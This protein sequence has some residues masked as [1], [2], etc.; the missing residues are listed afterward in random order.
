MVTSR[1]YT[2]GF[3]LVDMV[4]GQGIAY[5]ADRSIYMASAIK[6]PYVVSVM[7]MHPSAA[8]T[9]YS[10]IQSITRVSS[11]EAY[12]ALRNHF[13]NACMVEWCRKAGIDPN[14]GYRRWTDMTPR[15]VC[16]LWM[17]N[18]RYFTTSSTGAMVGTWFQNPSNSP[19]KAAINGKY[20]TQT[21]G[22]W[23]AGSSAYY[24]AAND[25][26]IVYAGNR[27]YVVVILSTASAQ[28]HLLRTLAG[29]LNYAHEE[30]R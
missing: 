1:G 14:I 21:K 25:A 28:H 12:N 8:S 11:N 13:G 5:N 26:G 6:G 30:M 9:H 22:G 17:Q 7:N 2:V 10:T 15:E 4:T 27:P 23:I 20:V 24:Q 3:V 29:A 18:Y 19:I 16:M